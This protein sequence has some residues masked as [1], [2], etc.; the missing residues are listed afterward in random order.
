MP[1]VLSDRRATGYPGPYALRIFV[2][3][4]CTTLHIYDRYDTTSDVSTKTKHASR[5][6]TRCPGDPG[7]G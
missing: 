1:A 5:A 3:D 7:G 2:L 6:H 4:I